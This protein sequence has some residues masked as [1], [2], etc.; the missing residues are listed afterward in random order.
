MEG[1]VAAPQPEIVT[2]ADDMVAADTSADTQAAVEIPPNKK[3]ISIL[4]VNCSMSGTAFGPSDQCH[5]RYAC[6]A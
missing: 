4:H 2:A 5:V 1:A 6:T 3:V